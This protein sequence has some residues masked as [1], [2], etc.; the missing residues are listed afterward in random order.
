[1]EGIML[2]ILLLN[3]TF[4]N[5]RCY[6]IKHTIGVRIDILTIFPPMFEGPFQHSIIKRAVEKG[7]VEIHI[8]DIR[9]Y[10]SN[11]HKSVDDYPYCGGSGMVMMIQPIADLI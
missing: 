2:I 3:T 1:M 8:H 7:L 9:N 11:K 10:S 6:S 4:I 5:I